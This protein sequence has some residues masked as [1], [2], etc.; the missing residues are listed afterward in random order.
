ML[1]LSTLQMLLGAGSGVLVGFTLGLVGGGGSIL[2]VPLLVYLVGV[3]A[4]HLAIG[5]SAVAVA[6]NAAIGLSQHARAGHVRWPCAMVFAAAGV[7]GAAMGAHLGKRVDGQA[8]LGA[9]AVMMIVVAALMLLRREPGED[10]RVRLSRGNAP[11]LLGTGL[12][13]GGLSG[14]FGIG[15]GFL[16]VPGLILAAGMP[17]LQ[18]IGSSLVA[19][20]AFGLT[21]AGSY[22]SAGLVDWPLAGVFIAGGLAGSLLGTRAGRALARRRGLLTRIFAGLILL[23]AA[24]TLARSLGVAERDGGLDPVLHALGGL[25]RLARFGLEEGEVLGRQRDDLAHRQVAQAVEGG[26]VQGGGEHQAA[27]ARMRGRSSGEI[28]RGRRRAM[29]T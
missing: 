27:S 13:V 14:F 2:A 22:A 26:A 11:A 1:T 24:Y 17:M 19:V 20:T 12:V 28:R 29:A 3:P 10:R 8:L 6:A 16:I 9:F 25:D 4:P 23:V 15:G 18:A 7:L 21:T 5:T